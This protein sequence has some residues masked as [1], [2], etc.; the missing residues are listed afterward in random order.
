MPCYFPMEGWRSLEVNPSGKRSIVFNPKQGFADMPITVPCGSCIGC[1]LERSRQWAVRCVHE[2]S[3]YQNNSFITLTYRPENLPETGSLQF[4]D[5]QK[6]MK[7]L[8]KQVADGA[9]K[10]RN[11]LL[12]DSSN[13][14]YF[15]CGEYGERLS[16]PHY[17]ACLFGLDFGDKKVCSRNRRTGMIYYTSKS[18]EEIW[19]KGFVQVGEMNFETAAYAAR[20]VTK[21]VTGKDAF[22]Y[23]NKIDKETGEILEE[24]RPEYVTMSRRPGIGKGWLNKY[25][26]DVFPRDEVVMRGKMMKPPKYYLGQYEIASPDDYARLKGKRKELAK[27]KKKDNTA[28]RLAVKRQ[29]KEY[30]YKQLIRSYENED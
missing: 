9:S 16:R 1:R 8:R 29:V 13:I 6:F 19:G 20:Y 21:K 14:R 5:F 26:S 12:A 27:E 22:E 30:K 11:V 17:H 25:E 23:Y 3:L 7:R 28:E 15:H 2:A 10:Y 24:K 4:I 18:L